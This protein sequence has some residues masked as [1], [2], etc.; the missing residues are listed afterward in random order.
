MSVGV[1]SDVVI[2]ARNKQALEQTEQLIRAQAPG[3][4]VHSVTGDMEDMD[5]LPTLCTL[6]FEGIDM[7]KH[8]V[9]LLVNNAGTMN[10]LQT[11][12]L[13]WNDPEKIQSYMGIN[14]TS[15][16]VLTTRFLSAFPTS[17]KRYVVNI[18]SML[19]KVF[20]PKFLLYSSSRAARDAF[21][22][23]LGTELPNVRQF[24]YSPGP[25]DTDMFEEVRKNEAF[26]TVPL[27]PQQSIGK[28]V[29]LLNE[30]QFKNSSVVDYYDDDKL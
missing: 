16:V 1:P 19:A 15:M 21:M 6:L 4:G 20:V 23:V 28:L 26:D 5:A 7:S 29:K 24:S 2:T 8:K 13:S 3:V 9:G 17:G 10:N 30:D 11:P 14:F 25:C 27:N 12:F 18:T 22:G